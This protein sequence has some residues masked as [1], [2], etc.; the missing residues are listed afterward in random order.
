[1]ISSSQKD[2][3]RIVSRKE[4]SID[5]SFPENT[6]RP[7]KIEDYVGQE[8]IKKHLLVSISSAKI[9][10][11]SLE[12]IIFYGP[13]WLGKTTLANI[14]ANEMGVNIKSSS[15]PAIEK[16]SDMVSI[17]SNLEEGDIL[18]IDEIHRLKPQIEEILYTWMEDFSVDIMVGTWTGAQWVK[19]PLKKFTLIGATTKLSSLSAPLRDRFWNVLKLD[20]YSDEEIGKILLKNS[21]IIQLNLDEKV[22]HMLAKRARGTPRIANR[23]LKIIRDYHI[24]G[25]N[26]YKSEDLENI[27]YDIGIDS[28]GLDYLDRKYLQTLLEKFAWWPVWLNTISAAI[29]EEEWTLED[30]VEPYL[31]QVGFIERSPRWRKITFLWKEHISTQYNN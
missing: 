24:I 1:M 2:K 13:P 11:E 15:G 5:N 20:F 25:K 4:K 27:F 28:L 21:Q 14:I 17:L 19:L 22:I 10:Q 9:R 12:H 18:F 29:G 31:L 23:I 8:N 6:L 7:K 26:I 30:V 16:Q 3:Q